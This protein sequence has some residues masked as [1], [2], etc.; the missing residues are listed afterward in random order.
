[1]K[2][3]NHSK[4][5]I[6][7]GLI[8][9]FLS[10]CVI[11]GSAFR[12][13]DEEISSVFLTIYNSYAL[14]CIIGLC[15]IILM[16]LFFSGHIKFINRPQFRKAHVVTAKTVYFEKSSGTRIHLTVSFTDKNSELRQ[17][18]IITDNCK[19]AADFEKKGEG[20]IRY[21]IEEDG[22]KAIIAK[23]YISIGKALLMILAVLIP[24]A[25]MLIPMIIKMI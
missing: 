5:N 19:A 10:F 24:M 23:E 16:L 8:G 13:I 4:K 20:K 3:K 6:I 14:I 18:D 25:L 12:Y 11:A 17:C 22:I 7:H 1:M 15:L 21:I 2:K 9:G